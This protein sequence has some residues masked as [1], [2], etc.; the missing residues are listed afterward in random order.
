MTPTPVPAAAL[1]L[2]ACGRLRAPAPRDVPATPDADQARR[3]AEEEL[4]KPVYHQAAGL[5]ERIWQWLVEHLD[6]RA[7]VPGAPA[8][9]SVLI[10]VVLALALLTALVVLFARVTWARRVTRTGT[11]LFEDDRDAAALTRAADAAAGQ[12]DWTT[13]VVE[14]F[15]AIVRMLDERGVIEDYPG[16][17]AHEAALLA[18]RPLGELAAQMDEAARLFDAV[19]YGRV[20]SAPAQD[21]WMREFADR[22][23]RA[24]LAPPV[25]TGQV[26][27]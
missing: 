12:G 27:A 21:A 17:T 25:P 2:Y 4:A 19:R 22:V 3:A 26:P 16:M 18:A 20:V 10:V 15:R 6:P 8:W 23:A 1:G 11:A 13:A 5:W 7:A 24:P 14:R 9:L